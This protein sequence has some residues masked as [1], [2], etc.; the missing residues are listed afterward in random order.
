MYKTNKRGSIEG[1]AAPHP[2]VACSNREGSHDERG[3]YAVS[4]PSMI[5]RMFGK[6]PSAAELERLH[7]L[8]ADPVQSAPGGYDCSTE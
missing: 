8:I 4:G 7:S 1:K 3:A 2:G 5:Q 6:A